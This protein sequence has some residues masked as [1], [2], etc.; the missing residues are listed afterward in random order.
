MSWLTP[1]MREVLADGAA[2]DHKLAFFEHGATV[3]MVVQM[4]PST[5]AELFDKF[6]KNFKSE[7]EGTR[8]AYKTI[9]LAGGATAMPV[10]SNFQQMDFKVVQG[11]GETRIAAAAGVPP[12]IVGLSEGLA[13][14]TYSN[15]GQ[16]RRAFA[17]G[18][19]RPLWRSACGAL[20]TI[21]NVPG[22]A[23]LWYDDR[24]IQFLQEDQKDAAVI[25]QTQAATIHLFIAAGFQPD[26]VV[27][28]VLNSDLSRLAHT[29][30]YSVQLQPAM[31]VTEGKGAVVKGIPQTAGQATG[32]PLP[33][34]SGQNAVRALLEQFL[35]PHDVD[36]V[37]VDAEE[38]NP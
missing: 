18:T 38:A 36:L 19:M 5:T 37:V 35:P 28:A 17:D 29:G 26:S 31:S 2:T 34:A 27:S 1:V 23:D 30:L 20:E 9:F 21:V 11:A 33:A 6:V 3:N 16:A 14:A 4:D 15:Y 13:A 8:N 22:P 10:G 25:Q 24:D 32:E 12:I 7:H